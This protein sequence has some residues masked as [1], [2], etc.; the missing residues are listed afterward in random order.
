MCGLLP[1]RSPQRDTPLQPLEGITVV[2]TAIGRPGP[3]C[4][5]LLADTGVHVIKVEPLGGDPFRAYRSP[6]VDPHAV[7]EFLGIN[8]NK[9]SIALDDRARE[10]GEIFQAL[11][12]KADV[13]SADSDP[14]DGERPECDE[15]MIMHRHPRLIIA[16][17]TLCARQG[18]MASWHGIALALFARR[19]TARGQRVDTSLP[20]TA[21][22]MQALGADARFRS[23]TDRVAGREVLV[24]QLAVQFQTQS[25][26]EWLHRLEAVNIPCTPVQSLKEVGADPRLLEAGWQTRVQHP[27][28]GLLRMLS[29]PLQFSAEPTPVYLPAP[30]PGQHTEAILQELGYTAK[31]LSD[32]R[33]KRVVV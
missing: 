5:T 23:N 7:R 3:L 9:R 32:L 27:T 33:A 4:A 25:A 2:E 1:C 6:H 28:L 29:S 17:F 22:A 12:A 8:R 21:A 26:H 10:G 20:H 24:A 13:L 30:L 31:D 15:A 11:L 14:A 19:R 18:P 16:G